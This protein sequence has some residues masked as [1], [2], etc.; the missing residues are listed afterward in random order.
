[1]I[2][3]AVRRVGLLGCVGAMGALL[4]L[5]CSAGPASASVS[6]GTVS[7]RIGGLPA[8]DAPS[9]VLTVPR[10]ASAGALADRDVV[11]C[12][13]GAVHVDASRGAVAAWHWSGEGG[14]PSRRAAR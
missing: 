6:G 10:A 12:P 8:G 4:V 9:A 14:G 3:A 5:L 11:A 7:V 13:C 1:M 2:G